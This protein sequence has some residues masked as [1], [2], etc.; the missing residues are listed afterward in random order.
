MDLLAA[1]DTPSLPY[2]FTSTFSGLFSD[3]GDISDKIYTTLSNFTFLLCFAGLLLAA[4]PWLQTQAPLLFL[5]EQL[6][7][8]ILLALFFGR[9]LTGPGESL[10]TQMARRVHGGRHPLRR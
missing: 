10:V 4:W 9:S 7:V 1:I 8:Y 2:G 6:G 3:V 5:L